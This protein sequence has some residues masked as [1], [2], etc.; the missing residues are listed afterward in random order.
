MEMSHKMKYAQTANT[1]QMQY[2]TESFCTNHIKTFSN[3]LL[4]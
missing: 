2:F 3:N 4:H 1:H